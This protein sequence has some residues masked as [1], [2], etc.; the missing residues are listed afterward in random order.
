MSNGRL[1]LRR[2]TLAVCV[3]VLMGPITGVCPGQAPSEKMPAA[4]MPAPRAASSPAKASGSTAS[5]G[6]ASQ[7]TAKAGQA[8][9]PKTPSASGAHN[10]VPPAQSGT[11]SGGGPAVAARPA[12]SANPSESSSAAVRRDPFKA[13]VAP[14]A[15]DHSAL[16]PVRL[17]AGPRGLVISGL[18]LEGVVRQQPADEMIAVVTNDTKRAYFLRVNDIVYNGVVSKIT[19]VAIHFKENTLDSRGR[20]VTRDVEIKLGSALGEGR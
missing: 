18:R 6:P 15:A 4:N 7:A 13:W 12:K 14:S 2:A 9:L 11:A 3:F 16:E 20:V 5:L 1:E 17:P 10:S 19:P 8:G